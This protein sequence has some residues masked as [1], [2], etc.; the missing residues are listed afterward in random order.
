MQRKNSVATDIRNQ[1]TAEEFET[2]CCDCWEDYVQTAKKDDWI[3]CV[4]CRNWLREFCSPCN[5]KCFECGRK[6]LR[7]KYSK[8]QKMIEKISFV[9]TQTLEFIW[10]KYYVFIF[11]ILMLIL[12]H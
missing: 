6:L 7:E 5:H 2:N 8:M 4:N 12:L 3:E 10:S 9:A 1:H 11:S